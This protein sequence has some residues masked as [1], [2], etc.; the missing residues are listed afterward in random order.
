[1]ADKAYPSRENCQIVADKNGEPFL[2][3]KENA[4]SAAKGKPAWK[5]SYY[6]YT[7][8]EK[9]WMEI[10][11]QREIVEA[12]FSSIKSTGKLIVFHRYLEL[13]KQ[14]RNTTME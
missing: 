14:F 9:E 1:M 13:P 8:N 11:Y 7:D 4:I 5:I 6:G 3:F 2:H 10:Y 12:V